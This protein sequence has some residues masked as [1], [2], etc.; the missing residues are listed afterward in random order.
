MLTALILGALSA[1]ALMAAPA[2][3]ELDPG[4]SEIGFLMHTTWH[5]V[6][7]RTNNL[8]GAIASENGDIFT[9]GRVSVEVEAAGLDT[10]NGRRDR[11]MRESHLE[12]AKYPRISFVS[13][14]PPTVVSSVADAGGAP[15]EVSL[16][17]RGDLTIH[18]TTRGV[19]LPVL[20]RREGGIW[21]LSGELSVRLSEYSI[22]DPSIVFNRVQDEVRVTFTLR[23]KPPGP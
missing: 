14:V 7:G 10:G 20:A 1:A 12:T 6:E 5:D 9:D 15:R 3:V 19:T 8:S 4:T 16:T 22:P 13:T 21:I 23:T 11:T 2:R 18:G 17:V